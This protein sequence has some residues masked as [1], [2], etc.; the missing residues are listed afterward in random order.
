MLTAE[1]ISRLDVIDDDK[2]SRDLLALITVLYDR[3]QLSE[4][5]IIALGE[6]I[7]ILERKVETGD[8][9]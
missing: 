9:E 3:L 1:E 5:Q 8:D 7:A 4:Y 6:R 2:I